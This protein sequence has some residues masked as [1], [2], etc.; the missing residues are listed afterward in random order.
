MNGVQILCLS[1]IGAELSPRLDIH[2]VN[3]DNVLQADHPI[4][5]RVKHI[6]QR[7]PHLFAV[8]VYCRGLTP[9]VMRAL[10]ISLRIRQPPGFDQP[11]EIIFPKR[12][13]HGRARHLQSFNVIGAHDPAPLPDILTE[14]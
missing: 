4:I 3:G 5:V 13:S 6:Q 2:R 12:C 1:A 11:G 10:A 8:W 9:Q 14:L 7:Q